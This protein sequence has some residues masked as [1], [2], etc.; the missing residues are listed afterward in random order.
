MQGND[1]QLLRAI[2]EVMKLVKT[3]PRVLP[4]KPAFEDRSAKGIKD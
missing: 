1:P 2:E 3:S 4:P